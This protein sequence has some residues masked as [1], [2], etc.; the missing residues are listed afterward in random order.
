ML[1]NVV[2]AVAL[3]ALPLNAIMLGF[4]VLEL[5]SCSIHAVALDGD[6]LR[7]RCDGAPRAFAW[8]NIMATA[9]LSGSPGALSCGMRWRDRRSPDGIW[10]QSVSR[11]LGWFAAFSA[12]CSIAI[13]MLMA[14]LLIRAAVT[15]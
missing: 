5:T 13:I 8:F 14:G 12:L 3:L 9:L 11:L 10:R 1:K 7:L 2:T 15:R 4:L 6:M